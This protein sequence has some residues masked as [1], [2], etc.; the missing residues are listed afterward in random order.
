ME[1]GGATIAR[2]GYSEPH[3]RAALEEARAHRLKVAGDRERVS[4]LGGE[5]A[6]LVAVGSA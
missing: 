1:L 4:L 2:P 5:L 6:Q 3:P